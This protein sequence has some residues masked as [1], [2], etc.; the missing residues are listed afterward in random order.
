MEKFGYE[1]E[2]SVFKW[3]LD[4]NQNIS[5]T[6]CIIDSRVASPGH[7]IGIDPD[8]TFYWNDPDNK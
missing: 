6:V 1:F 4:P 3:D 2:C 7:F 5:D 8:P